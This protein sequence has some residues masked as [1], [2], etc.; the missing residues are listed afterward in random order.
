MVGN[1]RQAGGC[2]A[3]GAEAAPGA[4]KASVSLR[5]LE[6]ISR[7]VYVHSSFWVLPTA[8]VF[9]TARLKS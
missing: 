2:E 5:D 4:G 9:S 8:P 1:Q 7:N 6:A 3:M